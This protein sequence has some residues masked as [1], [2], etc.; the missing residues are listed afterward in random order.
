MINS[1]D[2]IL[3]VVAHPDDEFLWLW[4]VYQRRDIEKHLVVICSDLRRKGPHRRAA[5]EEVCKQENIQ[6][7]TCIDIDNNFG[8]LPT[9]RASYLLTDAVQEIDTVVSQAVSDINPDYVATHN[10]CGEYGHLSHRLLFELVS[11]NRNAR[12]V[13]FTDISQES[14][15]RSSSE[16]PGSVRDAYYR[17]QINKQAQYLDLDFYARC[18]KIYEDHQAYTWCYPPIETCNLFI[19]NENN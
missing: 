19:I 1:G 7:H 5:L 4:S 12:N 3:G 18:K 14:N 17:K 15:H 8:N 6:L 9:R 2:K 13:I 16:I 10:I 11:Q